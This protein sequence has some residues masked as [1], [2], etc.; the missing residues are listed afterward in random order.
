MK[1]AVKKTSRPIRTFRPETMKPIKQLHF[2][3]DGAQYVGDT[4]PEWPSLEEQDAWPPHTRD[5]HIGVAF[6][7][8]AQTQDDSDTI[9]LGLTAL[10]LSGHF[11]D[12]LTVINNSSQTFSVTAAKLLR[13]AHCGLVLNFHER[14]FIAK[15]IKMCVNNQKKIVE[16][17]PAS[18]AKPT[19]QDYILIKLRKVKG[20]ID[21]A[22][23]D[24]INNGYK[25]SKVTVSQLLNNPDT[26]IPSNRTKDL[27]EYCNRYLTEYRDALASKLPWVEAYPIGKRKL[28][29]AVEWWEQAIADTTSFGLRKQSARKVRAR[30]QKTPNQLISKV[31]FLGEFKELGLKSIDPAS[32]LKYS[33]LWIYNTRLRKLG[34]YVALN[35]MSFEIKGT[36]IANLDPSKSV[37]RTLRKP[38]E[39]LKELGNYSNVGAVKWFNNIHAVATPLRPAISSDCILLK[40]IK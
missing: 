6:N 12:L 7:W 1:S 24:F 4:E 35:G 9:K 15:H 22:F 28:K 40:G 20:E 2:R 27:V 29:A 37:Q 26:T 14:R 18:P 17:D 34:R 10:G 32:L 11:P 30:K 38:A 19:I 13:M 39:Q 33:E 23:D 36:K 25:E 3:G 5:H 8:Y 21:S 16:K 31:K